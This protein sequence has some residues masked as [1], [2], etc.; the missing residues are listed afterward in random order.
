VN[1]LRAFASVLVI[2]CL[3]T[4]VLAQDTG[5]PTVVVEKGN[6]LRQLLR[7][8]SKYPQELRRAAVIVA[9]HP[10][11]LGKLYDATQ[12][13]DAQAAVNKLLASHT[14]DVQEAGKR[15]AK[16][17]DMLEV[18]VGYQ[19]L[20]EMIGQAYIKLGEQKLKEVI[21]E[22]RNEDKDTE[23][24]LTRWSRRL[25][26][27]KTALA[28]FLDAT[29]DYI[30]EAKQE[31]H[32]DY[33]LGVAVTPKNQAV[34]YSLPAAPL[35]AFVLV[36]ADV[37]TEL[38][39]EMVEQWLTTSSND[40]FDVV[41]AQWWFVLS[42]HFKGDVLT[43]KGR[44]ERLRALATLGKK[45][46]EERQGKPATIED[47][48]KFLSTHAAEFPELTPYHVDKPVAP[49]KPGEEGQIQVEKPRVPRKIEGGASVSSKPPSPPPASSTSKST[50]QPRPLPTSVAQEQPSEE[51]QVRRAANNQAYQLNVYAPQVT[52]NTTG[53][54]PAGYG[55]YY[56]GYTGF[57]PVNPY[58]YSYAGAYNRWHNV[59]GIG[60]PGGI[61]GVG[62]VGRPGGIGAGGALRRPIGG[63]R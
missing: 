25:G 52:A 53:A 44:P 35:T 17:P 11:L 9:Q 33:G 14:S 43:P 3:L 51:Q 40:H 50:F 36:N 55:G 46:G 12:E 61:G 28:Q 5:K 37:Y 45:L 30:E 19:P 62:G 21:D 31:G 24:S 23:A 16:T 58:F 2:G 41:M 22:L 42:Q 34:V 60:G 56:P 39:D 38:A 20:C 8:V 13:P 49:P 18:L 4:A 48:M 63:R 6:Q 59:G 54:Y 27:N 26:Q 10:K 32:R 47:R 29:S 1:P 15:L 7:D 57:A